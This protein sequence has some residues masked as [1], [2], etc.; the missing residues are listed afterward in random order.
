MKIMVIDDREDF[1]EAATKAIEA[2][3]HTVMIG[4]PS[5]IEKMDEIRDQIKISDMIIADIFYEPTKYDKWNRAI[6]L[7][8]ADELG[9]PHFRDAWSK[10]GYKNFTEICPRGIL[11]WNDPDDWVYVM[12]RYEAWAAARA[13]KSQ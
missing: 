8:Y 5:I 12:K 1:L 2:A 13:S 7:C 9:K 10:K 6:L 4:N 11:N 3:G